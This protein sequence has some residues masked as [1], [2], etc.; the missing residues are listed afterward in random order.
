MIRK[1]H[2]ILIMIAGLLLFT[3]QL[4]AQERSSVVRGRVTFKQTGE[5][6]MGVTVVEKDKDN[7]IVNGVATDINGTFQLKI[8]DRNDSLHF[9]QVGMKEVVRSIKNRE[10]VNVS[11]EEES[12]VLEEVAVTAKRVA[13]SGGFFTPSDRTA[14]VTTIDLKELEEIP[15]ASVDQIL[16]GQ[17]PGLMIS[18]NSGDPGSGSAIQ[19]RGA[20]SLGLGTKPLIVVD[21]VPFKTEEEVDV[22]NPDGLS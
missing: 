1:N 22:N 8:H 10:I 18:M 6:L 15:A 14:A 19:I 13:S 3:C 4:S 9:T 11:M 7:R 21:D 5:P 17:V 20:A 12:S 2:I 16:E